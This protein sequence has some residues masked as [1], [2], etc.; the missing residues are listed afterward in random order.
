[1]LAAEIAALPE[2]DA[3]ELEACGWYGVAHGSAHDKAGLAGCPAAEWLLSLCFCPDCR[4][5]YAAA[6]GDPV[7]VLASVR[8]AAD[9]LLAGA[10]PAVAAGAR[11]QRH[12][13]LPAEVAAVVDTARAAVATRFVREVIAAVRASA[14][15][16]SVYLH[17]DPDPRAA[18]ANPGADPAFLLGRGGADGIVLACWDPA[19]AAALVSRAVAAAPPGSGIAASLL[20]VAGLGGDPASLPAQAGAV[21]AA[22]A[23]ELRLYHAG[24]AGPADLAAIRAFCSAPAAR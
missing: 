24:L 21:Q 13:G 1:M 15:G 5:A 10:G 16:K 2:A 20:A 14:P 4:D 6:G 23:T 7:A 3:I 9:R 17:A 22:G 11:T 19:R 12:A 8:V 18:G